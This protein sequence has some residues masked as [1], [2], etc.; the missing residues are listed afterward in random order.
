MDCRTPGVKD[1]VHDF[2]DAFIPYVVTHLI[3]LKQAKCQQ[4]QANNAFY[5]LPLRWHRRYSDADIYLYQDEKTK[6][7]QF[8]TRDRMAPNSIHSRYRC[9]QEA[10]YRGSAFLARTA[11]L[12]LHM[13][14]TKKASRSF[15]A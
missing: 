5:K 1:G 8:D 4:N 9:T 3:D 7:Q 12:V 6:P 14:G 10:R 15:S 13:A 2:L 11:E